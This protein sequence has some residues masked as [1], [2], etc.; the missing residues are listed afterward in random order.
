MLPIS[1]K[2]IS[3]DE[4]EPL[5]ES[6]IPIYDLPFCLQKAKLFSGKAYQKY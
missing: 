6:K 1:V 4:K 3:S 2:W 5:T